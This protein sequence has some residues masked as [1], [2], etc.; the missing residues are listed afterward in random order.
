LKC[1]ITGAKGQD[2]YYLAKILK[3][4]GHEVF[5]MVYRKSDD[6]IP[7]GEIVRG[8]LA[9]ASSINKLVKDIQPDEIYNMGSLS[10][11]GYSFLNPEAVMNVNGFGPVRVYEAVKNY[12]PKTRIYQASTSEMFGSVQPP[13]NE[14]SHFKPTNPYGAAKLY[15]HNMADI[16]RQQGLHITCGILFNHV[17]PLAGQ[18]FIMNKLIQGAKAI[19]E[20]RLDVIRVGQLD[21]RR[22]FGFAP[23]FMQA[24]INML[25]LPQPV[26]MVIGTGVDVSIRDLA[27]RIFSRFDLDFDNLHLVDP[28]LIRPV[29]LWTLKADIKKAEALINWHPTYTW[30]II[31]DA[32]TQDSKVAV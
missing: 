10:H 15:A 21:S 2:G 5:G 4:Q 16:Y 3:E 18:Y 11:A 13:H 23:E 8:D 19:S 27:R 32:M 1:L 24:T 14:S 26:D 31:V 29:E 25:R 7:L 9:D 12:S 30:D 20:E 6:F 17:S 22:D 28:E